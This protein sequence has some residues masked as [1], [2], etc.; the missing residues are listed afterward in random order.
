MFGGG[1]PKCLDKEV[2]GALRRKYIQEPS[3]TLLLYHLHE[4]LSEHL[5]ELV[6]QSPEFTLLNIHLCW[7]SKVSQ[8]VTFCSESCAAPSSVL[9]HVV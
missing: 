8:M 4:Q 7:A 1:G 5:R 2:D 6:H 3:I 9:E